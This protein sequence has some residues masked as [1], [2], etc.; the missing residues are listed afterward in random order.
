MTAHSPAARTDVHPLLG[1]AAEVWLLVDSSRPGGIESHILSLATGLTATGLRVLVVFLADHGPHPLRSQ[2]DRAAQRHSTLS[3]SFGLFAAL[4]TG[5]PGLLHTHG[6]KAGILGRAAARVLGIPVVSTYHSGEPGS[7]RLKLYAALDRITAPLANCIA[8]SEAIRQTLPCRADL[9]DNFVELPPAVVDPLRR[10]CTVAFVG[11]LSEEKGPDTFC[12]LA[13]ALPGIAF[14][15]Y[16]DGHMRPSLEARYAGRVRFHG[17][18]AGMREHWSRVGLLCMP[19]RWEGLP[20][21]ALEAMSHGVPVA[22]FAVGALPRVIEHGLN[23]WLAPA[24]DLPQL[25]AAV[26][27]WKS[28]DD[29]AAA[30]VSAAARA[31]VERRFSPEVGIARVLEVYASALDRTARR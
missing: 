24:G 1:G 5:R 20:M 9:I 17:M 14:E 7:G 2:L 26:Q 25:I 23:G 13:E 16:G 27:T 22:A 4:R 6:Y 31:T 30:A 29:A 15:L 21:A 12:Q 8:V 3:G 28:Q 11:R 18:V 19:S 10:P